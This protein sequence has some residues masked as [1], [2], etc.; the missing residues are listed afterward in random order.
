V[1]QV[2]DDGER[3]VLLQVGNEEVQEE[4]LAT[5]GR[6]QD[7]RVYHVIDVE[8]GPTARAWRCAPPGF[9]P[10]MEVLQTGPGRSSC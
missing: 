7:E 2:E 10:G 3:V 5:P 9:E 4:A 6:P 8:V 1:A